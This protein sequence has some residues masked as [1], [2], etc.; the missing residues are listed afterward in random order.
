M[1]NWIEAEAC[2]VSED[3]KTKSKC[4][5]HGSVLVML[6]KEGFYAGKSWNVMSSSG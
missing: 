2:N 5:L 4:E 6:E 1:G 3:K